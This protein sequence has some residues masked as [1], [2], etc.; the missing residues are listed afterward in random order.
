MAPRKITRARCSICSH[1]ERARIELSRVAGVSLRQ[2]EESFGVSG[3]AVWRHMA[4]H[5]SDADRA[6]YLAD[7]PLQEMLA[8]A[9]DEGVSL[10]DFFKLVRGTLMKQFQLAASVNDRRA[11]AS[12]AGRLN[13]VLVSIGG[14]TGEMLKLSPTSITNNTAV[15]VNSP[16]FIDLQSMLVRKLA[17]HPEALSRV[18]EGLQELEAKASQ[19]Q[20]GA[21]LIDARQLEHTDAA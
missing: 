10:L 7:I 3:Q 14:V 15:F 17:G 6:E 13:E 19:A 9:A 2:I 8:R 18:V 20:N 5:V 1:P 16:M 4:N 12:L 21:T 11:V